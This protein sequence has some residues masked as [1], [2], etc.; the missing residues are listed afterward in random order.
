VVTGLARTCL[1][2]GHKVEVILPFYQCLPESSIEG[3]SHAT[4]FDVPKVLPLSCLQ[5]CTR[6]HGSFTSTAL[7]IQLGMHAQ[8]VIIHAAEVITRRRGDAQGVVA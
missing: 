3:L 6:G 1:E 4:D 7:I 5:Q 8:Q 2:M